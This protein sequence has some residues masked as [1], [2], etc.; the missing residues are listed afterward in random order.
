MIGIIFEKDIINEG[1]INNRKTEERNIDFD[2]NIKRII[3]IDKIFC[4][5]TSRIDNR[6]NE[7]FSDSRIE[8]ECKSRKQNVYFI[9]S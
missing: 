1:K 4:L 2:D 7:Y 9:K 3:N 6:F 8:V 5:F